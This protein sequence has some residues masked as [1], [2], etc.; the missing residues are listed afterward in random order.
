MPSGTGTYGDQV[1]RPT[2]KSVRQ[3]ASTELKSANKKFVDDRKSLKSRKK[4]KEWR[5]ERDER[6]V[7]S[8]KNPN[9]RADKK[10]SMMKRWERPWGSGGWSPTLPEKKKGVPDPRF[11]KKRSKSKRIKMAVSSDKKARTELKHDK[12]ISGEGFPD[13]RFSPNRKQHKEYR[14]SIG[15]EGWKA[16]GRGRKG[17]NVFKDRGKGKKK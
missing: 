8:F 5:K 13:Q 9:R 16:K 17:K 3:D 2:K 11:S 12:M 1:G 14:E 10:A 6:G 7:E 4:H 15:L